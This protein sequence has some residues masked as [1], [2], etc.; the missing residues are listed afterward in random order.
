MVSKFVTKCTHCDTQ[1]KAERAH[2][3]RNGRCPNCQQEFRLVPILALW[4]RRDPLLQQAQRI[5]DLNG[6]SHCLRGILASRL[7]AKRTDR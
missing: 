7:R 2:M 1:V 6:R 4:A 5:V 3:G